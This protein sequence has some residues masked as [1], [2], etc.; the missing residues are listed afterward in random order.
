MYTNF[1]RC[2]NQRAEQH[3]RRR[4]GVVGVPAEDIQHA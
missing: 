2:Q 4:G 1:A 3:Q